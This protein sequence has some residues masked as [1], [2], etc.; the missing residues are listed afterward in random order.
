MEA[1]ADCGRACHGHQGEARGDELNILRRRFFGL[2]SGDE[3]ED[4]KVGNPENMVGIKQEY[5]YLGPYTL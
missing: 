3:H 4:P 5:T 1:N 2:I